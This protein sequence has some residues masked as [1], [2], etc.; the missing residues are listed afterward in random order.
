MQ[1]SEKEMIRLDVDY[2]LL[3][4]GVE[5]LMEDGSTLEEVKNKM[6]HYIRNAQSEAT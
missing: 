4:R 2:D 3:E 1:V 5:D 6:L